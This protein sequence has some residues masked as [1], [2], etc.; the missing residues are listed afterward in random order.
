M[1][2]SPSNHEMQDFVDDF[3][4]ILLSGKVLQ[5]GVLGHLRADGEPLLQL[6]LHPVEQLLVLGGGEALGSRQTSRHG[7]VQ[8]RHLEQPQSLFDVPKE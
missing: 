1:E 7:S 4:G 3:F 6:L 2:F 5:D 8:S